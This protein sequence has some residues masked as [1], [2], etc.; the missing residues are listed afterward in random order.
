M[1]PI[2][3]VG[4]SENFRTHHYIGQILDRDLP[5]F[6]DIGWT[7]TDFLLKLASLVTSFWRKISLCLGI[8]QASK[9]TYPALFAAGM[10]GIPGKPTAVA[11]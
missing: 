1:S 5:S 4:C 3:P 6:S 8:I 11:M 10:T 2:I 7:R 9:L